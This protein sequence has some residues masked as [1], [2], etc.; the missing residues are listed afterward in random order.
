MLE[1][2]PRDG[3]IPE[4]AFFLVTIHEKETDRQRQYQ[5][6]LTALPEC[7]FTGRHMFSLTNHRPD[8]CISTV[9]L[10]IV[11]EMLFKDGAVIG[12]LMAWEFYVD[13]QFPSRL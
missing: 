1:T 11:K 7:R 6:L 13:L 4:A 10:I 2:D 12:I 5:Q 9:K 8:V 3:W